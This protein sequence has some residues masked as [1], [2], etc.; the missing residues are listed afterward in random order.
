MAL[1][2]PSDARVETYRNVAGWSSRAD[3]SG[4]RFE[5]GAERQCG[6]FGRTWFK[7]DGRPVDRDEFA[8]RLSEAS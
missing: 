8:R 7:I 6:V 5:W 1:K 2:F 3:V 4:H